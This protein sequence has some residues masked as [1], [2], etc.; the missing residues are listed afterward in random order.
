MNKVDAINLGCLMHI[1]ELL[2]SKGA[3]KKSIR[4]S[5]EWIDEEFCLSR[6]ASRAG[7]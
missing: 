4:N 5:I 1:R 3:E 2:G 7:I 6:E